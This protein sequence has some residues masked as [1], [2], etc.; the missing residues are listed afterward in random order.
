M[1]KPAVEARGLRK[2]LSEVQALDGLS[3]AVPAGFSG[4]LRTSPG[5]RGCFG[6]RS[7]Y[8]DV[9]AFR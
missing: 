2:A 7:R 4:P 3:L 6:W 8:P 9:D 5:E 1:S